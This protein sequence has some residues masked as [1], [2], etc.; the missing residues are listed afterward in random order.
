MSPLTFDNRVLVKT[1]IPDPCA[2]ERY[3]PGSSDFVHPD[4]LCSMCLPSFKG[5]VPGGIRGLSS[6]I[7]GNERREALLQPHVHVDYTCL[8]MYKI[9][10]A[11][12]EQL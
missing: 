7:D 2:L 5:K 4:P 1:H 11:L 9:S 10:P 6:C 12:D 8:S 3:I